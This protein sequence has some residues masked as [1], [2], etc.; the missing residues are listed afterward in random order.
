VP[1]SR[2]PAWTSATETR[3]IALLRA[4]NLAGKS[5]L[6][7]SDLRSLLE[8]LG[9]VDP[10]TLLQSGNVVFGFRAGA[11]AETPAQIEERI[12]QALLRELSLASDTFVRSAAEWEAAVAANPFPAEAKA[13]PGHLLLVALKDACSAASVTAL[14]AWIPGPERVAA[15]GR[16]LYVVYPEGVG[17]SKLTSAVIERKLDTRGTARNWNTVLKLAAAVRG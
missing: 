3:V 1:S 4:V 13:D 5:A 15:V 9:Y 8:G 6:R 16:H 2:P 11:K 10:Q 7:M 12:Q 14:Q 17:R